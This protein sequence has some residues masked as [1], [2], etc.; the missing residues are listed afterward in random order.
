M[1]DPYTRLYNRYPLVPTRH[2]FR[3][4][5]IT[6]GDRD[7]P[8]H[9][10]LQ[11]KSLDESPE[12]EALSYVWGDEFATRPLEVEDVTLDVTLNLFSSLRALRPRP[13]TSRRPLWVDAVDSERDGD[14]ES[15]DD[16]FLSTFT[17]LITS[18]A[19]SLGLLEDVQAVAGLTAF[20]ELFIQTIL[21]QACLTADDGFQKVCKNAYWRRIWT[22]QE[23]EL[24]AAV[25]TVQSIDRLYPKL[26]SVVETLPAPE[27]RGLANGI[28]KNMK[29]R[30]KAERHTVGVLLKRRTKMRQNICTLFWT[31]HDCEYSDLKDKVYALHRLLPTLATAHPPDY[32]RDPSIVIVEALAFDVNR[33]SKMFYLGLSCMS[34]QPRRLAS[35]RPRQ[36]SSWMPA[37]HAGTKRAS[38][39]SIYLEKYLPHGKG[40]VST[41][42]ETRVE[43]DEGRVIR[44]SIIADQHI[45]NAPV[46]KLGGTTRKLVTFAVTL[47]QIQSQLV[48]LVDS[49]LKT[50]LS[51]SL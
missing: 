1:D 45:L 51:P 40:R 41:L 44:P 16:N 4:L 34:L 50:Q 18:R 20:K 3:L 47:E 27:M 9:C 42:F 17:L 19:K 10:T 2:D 32:N 43:D 11:V 37:V 49:L 30:A 29:S 38:L 21:L 33:R 25:P 28:V 26:P 39:A 13:G 15:D 14:S 8:I 24:P 7:E 36:Y 5:Y 22:F 6:P 35:D 12:F 48:S 46:V 31:T 23:Y